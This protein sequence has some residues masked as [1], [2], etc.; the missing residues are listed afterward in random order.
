MAPRG[1]PLAGPQ[2]PARTLGFVNHR[3]GHPDV[4]K[5][6]QLAI[7]TLDESTRSFDVVASS[8]AI[9]SHGEIVKQD[10][11]LDRYAGNPVVFFGHE[12]WDLPI[13]KASDVMVGADGR[14]QARVTLV[15]AAA[16]P[17]AEQVMQLM[18]EGALKGVS[19]G[20]RPGRM[21][22]QKVDGRD[23]R[24][25]SENELLEISIVGVPANAEARA[26]AEGTQMAETKAG[27]KMGAVAAALGINVDPATDPAGFVTALTEALS[28]MLSELSGGS[29]DAPA[30]DAPSDAPPPEEMAAAKA[31]MR[32]VG[33]KDATD[34]IVTVGEWRRLAVEHKAA[35]QKLADDAKALESTK[36]RSLTARLVA[37]GAET[38]A[39]AWAD[40]AKTEPAEHLAS[41]SL[42]TLEKRCASF[43][44]RGATKN[45]T[46]K[47]VDA[48][49]LSERELALC[50]STGLDPQLYA[51]G[52]ALRTKKA[53]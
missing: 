23:V 1:Q 45:L 48:S 25:L 8:A 42:E 9:D 49:G 2:G 27:D 35:A 10:W 33:A 28:G 53:G 44:A 43:E 15:S 18:K 38:P 16:N 30:P 13:G 22:T 14:L 31:I 32:L 17:R 20:F 6:A 47:P 21:D 52:K 36:R 41:M 19:V 40:D 3:A 11:K 12:S 26:K 51:A 4:T 37:A 24:V 7:G 50:K 29:P 5:R 39:T 34:A 46:P